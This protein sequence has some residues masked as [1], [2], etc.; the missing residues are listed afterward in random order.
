M[1]GTPPP[2]LDPRVDLGRGLVLPN[3]VGVASGTFGYGFELEQLVDV[4]RLGA[5]FSKGTTPGPRQGNRPP[6]VAETTAGMLNAIGLQNP[7]VEVVASAYAPRWTGWR[8]PVVVN[9]AAEDIPGYVAVVRRLA[10]VPGV[11]GIELNISC[12]NIA[13]GLDFGQDPAAAARCVEAVRRATPAPLIVKLS[14]NVTD[15]GAVAR[16]VAAAGADAVSVV[17][18]YVGLK[19]SLALRR[20]VLP[21]AGTGGLSGP[22][23][24]P[25]ALAA[26]HRVRQAVAIPVV[27]VGGIQT[28]ADALEFFVVGADAVQVGTATFRNPTAALEVLD[29]CLAWAAAHGL[30]RWTDLHAAALPAGPDGRAEGAG[31]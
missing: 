6:R 4:Q 8:V 28:A 9:V 10:G 27:G 19:V 26:V 15:I 2:A 21:G 25:L 23:I 5:I 12:P 30:R 11:A 29:G 18:T 24:K 16:A 22:A 20:P 17:N 1:T 3:P 31:S 14:P 7:G 13:H